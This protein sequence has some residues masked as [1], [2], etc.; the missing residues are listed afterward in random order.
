MRNRLALLFVCLAALA[1]PAA[2]LGAHS[3]GTREQVAWVRRAAT[4]FVNAELAHDGSAACAV[5][6]APLRTTVHHRTCAQRQDA[7]LAG[8]LGDRAA[9]ARMHAQLH[10]IAAAIVV[11]HGNTASIA[12]S[13]PL[14]NG[15][16]RFLWTENCWMLEG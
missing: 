7:R 4:N 6:N 11:V 5:L 2:A 15:A 9:R 12:L 3:V 14:M 13:T 16:N 1:A 8:L 10:A